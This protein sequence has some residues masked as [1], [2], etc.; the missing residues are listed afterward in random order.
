MRRPR[1]EIGPTSF[2][3]RTSDHTVAA[4]TSSL[5][6]PAGMNGF[7]CLVLASVVMRRFRVGCMY[8]YFCFSRFDSLLGIANLVLSPLSFCPA[9]CARTFIIHVGY[10]SLVF[11]SW[12][13]VVWVWALLLLLLLFLLLSLFAHVCLCVCFFVADGLRSITQSRATLLTRAIGTP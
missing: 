4:L 7:L 2:T 13:V 8:F 11:V 1:W 6:S 5:V 10:S 12:L 9:V 3:G